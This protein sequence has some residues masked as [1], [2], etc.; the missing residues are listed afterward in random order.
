[1]ASIVERLRDLLAGREDVTLALLFGSHARGEATAASDVDIAVA[2]RPSVDLLTLAHELGRA[3]ERD[4][5]IVRLDDASIPLLEELVR[6]ATAVHEAQPS[7][8]GRW[9]ARTL[10]MLETDRPWF[11][12]MRDAWLQRVA[13]RGL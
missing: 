3:L 11:A 4:V 1:M 13:E 10:S 8:Y 5:Q 12:R 9:R 7:T 6:D 2:A